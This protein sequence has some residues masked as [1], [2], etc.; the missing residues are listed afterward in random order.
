MGEPPVRRLGQNEKTAR[1]AVRAMVA[2][3]VG[4]GEADVSRQWKAIVLASLALHLQLADSPIDIIQFQ[5]DHFARPQPQAGE[6]EEDSAI[7]R[8]G[9]AVLLVSVNNSLDFFRS[10][11]LRQ[12]SEPPNRHA[13]NGPSEVALRLTIEEEESKEGAQ[14]GYHRLGHSGAARAS[15]S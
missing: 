13:R 6:Q 4:Y 10:E 15:V 14:C 3:V 9:W 1:R 7:T 5:G 2:E 12:F 11:V 8:G